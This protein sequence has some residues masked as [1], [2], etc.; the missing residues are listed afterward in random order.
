M[1]NP[2]ELRGVEAES[3]ERVSSGPGT[4]MVLS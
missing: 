4:Y 2:Q 1:T 3:V